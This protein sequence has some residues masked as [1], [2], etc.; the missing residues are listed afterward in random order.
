MSQANISLNLNVNE[1]MPVFVEIAWAMKEAWDI[2]QYYDMAV[3]TLQKMDD[4]LKGQQIV[5]NGVKT[6]Y[7]SLLPKE[8][9]QCQNEF[10]ALFI[11]NAIQIAKQPNDK[12][13][14]LVNIPGAILNAAV[15]AAR[16]SLFKK[17]AISMVNSA[18]TEQTNSNE[19]DSKKE[20]KQ[21][22]AVPAFVGNCVIAILNNDAGKLL[23][24]I[25]E[26]NSEALKFSSQQAAVPVA[27]V[28]PAAGAQLPQRAGRPRPGE[29]AAVP[30]GQPAPLKVDDD[31][32]EDPREGFHD[33]L[34]EKY[35]RNLQQQQK[36]ASSKASKAP[37]PNPAPTPAPV[38][39]RKSIRIPNPF[40]R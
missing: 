17:K 1:V 25:Q 34:P 38:E 14:K 26:G 9:E 30:T 35:F 16:S 5:R 11:L 32:P 10:L 22:M 23:A 18:L 24:A 29:S 8:K 39:P 15:T 19:I 3:V 20:G 36:Q 4:Y 12:S 28:A 27:K 37:S 7:D 33:V 13:K 6:S 31:G 2:K 40:K 21:Y